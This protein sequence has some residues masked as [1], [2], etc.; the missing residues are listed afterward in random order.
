MQATHVKTP[1]N[2]TAVSKV[3]IRLEK[4]ISASFFQKMQTLGLGFRSFV[5]T[6]QKQTIQQLFWDESD[7]ELNHVVQSGHK[8]VEKSSDQR[9]G[10]HH[11]LPQHHYRKRSG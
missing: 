2:I 1:V 10:M 8:E 6:T 11:Q 4:L 9:P 5:L 3:T 7:L